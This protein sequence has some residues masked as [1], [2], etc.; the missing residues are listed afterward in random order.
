[1]YKSEDAK[2]ETEM[3]LTSF[4]QQKK[5]SHI[6]CA[7]GRVRGNGINT[8]DYLEDKPEENFHDNFLVPLNL[9]R[10]CHSR[11]IHFSYIGTGCI[12]KRSAGISPPARGSLS[13]LGTYSMYKESD[14]PNFFGSAYSRQKASL[15]LALDAL[16]ESGVKGATFRIRLPII[17]DTSD[18]RGVFGKLLAYPTVTRSFN[19]VTVVPYAFRALAEVLRCHPVGTFNLVNPGPVS[20]E[21]LKRTALRLCPRSDGADD[22]DDDDGVE[23]MDEDAE[24]AMEKKRSVCVLSSDKFQGL[25]GS[26]GVAPMPDTETILSAA[27]TRAYEA[28]DRERPRPATAAAASG[29][30]SSSDN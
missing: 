28:R 16:Y 26:I 2:Q 6:V 10:W 18:K 30:G 5:I 13:A 4:L 24:L 22:G 12:Y 27:E 14:P 19:S 1:M 20:N 29:G 3:A 17:F 8:I 25:C 9:C 7:T 11:N 23:L 21:T 15:D